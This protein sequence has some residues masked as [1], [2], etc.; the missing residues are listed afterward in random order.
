MFFIGIVITIIGLLGQIINN[1]IK[2][3]K[4]DKYTY[5][6]FV[7]GYILIILGY[8]LVLIFS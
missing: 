7:V 2:S 6:I 5:K 8:V 3:Y 1:K 4:L